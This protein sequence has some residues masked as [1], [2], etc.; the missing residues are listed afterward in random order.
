MAT[1]ASAAAKR[2]ERAAAWHLTVLSAAVFAPM[3]LHLPYFP[4]W[5][6]ARG[7]T[8]DQIAT[9][10][11]TP[12]IL[13]VVLTPAI[14]YVAD[15]RGIAA[16]LAFCASAMLAG[17]VA[18]GWLSGFPLIYMGALVLIVAQ[19]S[20]PALAD[21]LCLAEIRRFAKIG[22][23]KLHFARIRVGGTLSV[24]CG[25]LLSGFI[26]ATLP[27]EKI[28]FALAGIALLPVIV[29][30]ATA[31][32][33][34]RL[35]PEHAKTSGL[36]EDPADLRLAIIVILAAALVQ[37]SHAE[38]YAFGTLHWKV[39][40]LTPD[41]ISLAW[42][43]GVIAEGVLLMFGSR[44]LDTPGSALRF[45]IIGATGAVLRWT[46]MA[47]NPEPHVLLLLQITHALSFAATY[48]GAVLFLGSLAGPNHRARMQG[49]SSAAMAL[50][51]ALSTQA[52]G[53]LTT[54]YGERAYLAMAALAAIGCGLALVAAAL[55]RRRDRAAAKPIQRSTT[56]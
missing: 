44:Y 11:A 29:T 55:W 41:I 45:L 17:Y 21:A 27:G 34:P 54:L 53:K 1:P 43:T 49:F 37:A 16:T 18:L 31:L 28:I 8:D 32:R 51:M 47:A 56:A 14:A 50:S 42:A 10:L 36:T 12:L 20:M 23:N 30:I 46:I 4:V 26:V 3:G 13:R 6:A 48:I 25:M 40:G 38:I 52:C 15:R 7:L 39:S 9:T 22:L 33:M 2:S 35:R 5:L 24:L 19:G